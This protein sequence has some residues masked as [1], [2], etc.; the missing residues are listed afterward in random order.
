M[1]ERCLEG[2]W[3][4]S[5]GFLEGVWRVSGGCLECVSMVSGRFL[6]PKFVRFLEGV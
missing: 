2:V 1:F 5:G 6:D 3:M 4:A